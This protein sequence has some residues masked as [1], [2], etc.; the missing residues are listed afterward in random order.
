M[1]PLGKVVRVLHLLMILVLI[2]SWPTGELADDYKHA[3]HWGYTLHA[4]N[5]MLGGALLA[6]RLVWGVVGP[7]GIR[8][9][10]WLP[11]TPGRWKAALEDLIGLL[12][13]RLPR[14]DS[15][16]GLAGVVELLALLAFG[17]AVGTGLAFY[18]G[19]ETGQRAHGVMR[20]V[21]ES[22]ETAV[23]LLALVIALHVA[24]VWL[25]GIDGRQ[26]WMRMFFLKKEE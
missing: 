10:R 17:G 6:C 19:Q 5:G 4:W 2:I 15:H 11:V 9:V 12:R 25:H 24:A 3:S 21:K 18:L 16:E 22:H 26:L 7:P 23:G 20:L 13:L 14:R 8:F 1:T